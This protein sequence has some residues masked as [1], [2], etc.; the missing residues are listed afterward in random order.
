MLF[1][2]TKQYGRGTETIAE[3]F[4]VLAKAREY[5]QREANKDALMK[6]YPVYRLYEFDEVID[7]IDTAKLDTTPHHQQQQAQQ[8]SGSGAGQS[9]GFRPTPLGMAAKP[10]GS[11]Q[12]SKLDDEDKKD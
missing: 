3:S 5:M 1:K 4:S 12:Q 7:E 11:I 9:S 6:T 10:K 2:V 8:A